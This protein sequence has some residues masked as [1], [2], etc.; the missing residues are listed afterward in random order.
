MST[1]EA[2]TTGTEETAAFAGLEVVGPDEP[3][4][5]QLAAKATAANHA[6]SLRATTKKQ[7]HT[8]R[9]ATKLRSYDSQVVIRVAH[10]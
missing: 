1:G 7:S 9:V 5:E 2:S 8:Q 4:D 10:P 6:A 3:A